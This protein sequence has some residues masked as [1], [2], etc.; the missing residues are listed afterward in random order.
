MAKSVSQN[1]K[2]NTAGNNSKP[3]SQELDTNLWQA[4]QS[5]TKQ[6]QKQQDEDLNLQPLKSERQ[7]SLNQSETTTS[8][9]I[10]TQSSLDWLKIDEKLGDEAYL[11]SRMEGAITA[12]SNVDPAALL[13]AAHDLIMEAMVWENSVNP[14]TWEKRR[15]PVKAIK[16]AE[17]AFKLFWGKYVKDTKI[18]RNVTISTWP[19]AKW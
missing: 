6:S 11:Q 15:D 14:V 19:S 3:W 7:L 12:N 2:A 13:W 9:G 16:A 5:W 17:T 8:Q 18:F 10:Q 4:S 1:T